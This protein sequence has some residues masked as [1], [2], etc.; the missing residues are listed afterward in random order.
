MNFFHKTVL[1]FKRW[2][3]L[4]GSVNEDICKYGRSMKIW[5]GMVWVKQDAIHDEAKLL[6]P[7]AL[8][9]RGQI[10]SMCHAGKL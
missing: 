3:P 9:V 1:F 7:V 8:L 4:G 5:Y 10:V 6:V 2:L